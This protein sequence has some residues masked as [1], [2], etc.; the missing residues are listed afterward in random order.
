MKTTILLPVISLFLFLASCTNPSDKKVNDQTSESSESGVTSTDWQSRYDKL[1][2]S[3]LPD[4][5]IQLIGK[6]WMLVT[7]GDESS[8]NTM[9]ASWGGIGWLWNKPVAFVFVRPE[10][11]TY[12]FIEKSDYLTLSFLGEANKKIHAVC[13]SKS[14][15]DTD[16][17]KA[18]GLKPVFTEQG[19][20]LFEQARLSLEGRKLYA[21]NI[22]PECFLDKESLEKWYDDA[23]GGFH[24]MYIVEIENIW[25][26]D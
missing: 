13:G 24:K 3:D 23:H 22:K 6:E 19:N 2:A 7:A 18:T 9:T 5:V 11:Y 10:R 1:E 4:N 26:G 8:F 21:D 12:E 16:K 15:R 20:V 25:E 17:V 14:G